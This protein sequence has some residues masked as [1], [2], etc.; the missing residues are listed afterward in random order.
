MII[1]LFVCLED[2]GS[3]VGICGETCLSRRGVDTRKRIRVRLPL[4]LPPSSTLMTRATPTHPH[5]EMAERSK[6][7]A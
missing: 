2:G 5:G 3:H 6:A 4:P 1:P 7:L